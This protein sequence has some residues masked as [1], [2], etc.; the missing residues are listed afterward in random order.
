MT[1]DSDDTV[2]LWA[3]SAALI[4]SSCIVLSLKYLSGHTASKVCFSSIPFAE[5]LRF[6]TVLDCTLDKKK[7]FLVKKWVPANH[8]FPKEPVHQKQWSEGKPKR[9]IHYFPF[10]TSQQTQITC[11]VLVPDLSEQLRGG[12]SD[13][14]D[15]T[16]IT[17]CRQ[18][19]AMRYLIPWS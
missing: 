17:A 2:K 6:E 14:I 3:K 12:V 13:D 19:G 8:F 9:G 4:N 10:Q 5:N 1:E 18:Q 16:G 15:S 11:S 7:A